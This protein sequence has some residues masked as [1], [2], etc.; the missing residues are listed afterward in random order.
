MIKGLSQQKAAVESGY[1]QL[2]RFDPRKEGTGENPFTLDSDP[3]TL[4]LAEYIYT[5][6]RYKVLQKS[7]PEGAKVLLKGAEADVVRRRKFYES[8]AAE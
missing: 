1:W 4:P 7:D 8:L 3:A 6:G 5:E 2:F